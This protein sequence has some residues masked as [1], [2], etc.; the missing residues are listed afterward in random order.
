MQFLIEL[1]LAL[2]ILLHLDLEL[3]ELEI[4]LF[5]FEYLQLAGVTHVHLGHEGGLVLF[6]DWTQKALWLTVRGK[7]RIGVCILEIRRCLFERGY[8]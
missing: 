6:G 4:L 1:P 8:L 2:S 7:P 3:A 5:L